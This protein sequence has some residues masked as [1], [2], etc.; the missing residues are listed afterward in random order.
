MRYDELIQPDNGQPAIPIQI[1][2]K[3][4]FETWISEQTDA[5]RTATKAQKFEGAPNDMAIL[6]DDRPGEWSIVAE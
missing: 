6:P 3:I 1:V 5:V 2:D 4:G